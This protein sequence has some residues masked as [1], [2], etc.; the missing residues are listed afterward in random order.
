MVGFKIWFK[1][2]LKVVFKAWFKIGF[3][4]GF[5]VGFV[6]AGGGGAHQVLPRHFSIYMLGWTPLGFSFCTLCQ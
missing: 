3:K 6:A 2:V 5:K 1:V 4:A